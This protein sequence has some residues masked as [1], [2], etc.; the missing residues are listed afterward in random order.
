MTKRRA[1]LLVSGSRAFAK[2]PFSERAVEWA[3]GQITDEISRLSREFDLRVVTGDA[4]GPDQWAK[5]ASAYAKVPYV[6]YTK[7]G[8]R[9]L[10]DVSLGADDGN[11]APATVGTWTTASPP[12]HTEH[13]RWRE[14]L[15]ERDRVMATEVV[16]SA[17]NGRFVI[18]L[19]IVAPWSATHGTQHTLACARKAAEALSTD[20]S[21]SVLIEERVCP[22]DLWPEQTQS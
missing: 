13:E 5:N 8:D 15:L 18:V 2:P 22:K 17:K 3:V 7:H 14:W 21:L 1:V 12:R 11:R 19:G 20:D 9:K 6:V 10:A 4:T 16:Q